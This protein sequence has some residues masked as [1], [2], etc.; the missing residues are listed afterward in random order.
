MSYEWTK[1]VKQYELYT[2]GILEEIV[3]VAN[4]VTSASCPTNCSTYC[5]TNNTSDCPSDYS[6]NNYGYGGGTGYSG[7]NSSKFSGN[8]V[9]AYYSSVNTTN[10]TAQG[11]G[12]GCNRD[13][14][15][16]DQ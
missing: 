10:R 6:S 1:S 2:P 11:T 14:P 13:L 8:C 5:A 12:G 16:V 3:T 4:I 7:D 9:N 15:H